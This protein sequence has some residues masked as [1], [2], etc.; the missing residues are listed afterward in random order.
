MFLFI[1]V[2]GTFYDNRNRSGRSALANY[3]DP[4]IL[5]TFCILGPFWAWY[6]ETRFLLPEAH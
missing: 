4:I 3:R 1:P 6:W 2:R 5:I